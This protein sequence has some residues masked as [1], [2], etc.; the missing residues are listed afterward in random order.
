MRFHVHI[1]CYCF[2]TGLFGQAGSQAGRSKSK[3]IRVSLTLAFVADFVHLIAVVDVVAA[4]AVRRQILPGLLLKRIPAHFSHRHQQRYSSNMPITKIHAR[5]IYDSRGNPTVE[6]DLTTEK[7]IFRAAV[8]SGAST[9]ELSCP[10]M[11]GVFNLGD[12]SPFSRISGF[13][14]RRQQSMSNARAQ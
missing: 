13:S 7:G 8:P 5:M 3:P 11:V 4:V 12:I 9:G 2:L 6:V 14:S 10:V 1:A